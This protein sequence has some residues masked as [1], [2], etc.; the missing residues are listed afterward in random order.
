MKAVIKCECGALFSEE[1]KEQEF[2]LQ[3]MKEFVALHKSHAG[4][5]KFEQEQDNAEEYA[6]RFRCS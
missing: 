5:R 6:R 3:K 2:V 1:C 4:I